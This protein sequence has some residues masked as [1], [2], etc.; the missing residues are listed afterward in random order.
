M[1]PSLRG[2]GGPVAEEESPKSNRPIRVL[3]VDDHALFRRGL[4]ALLSSH[5]GLEIVGER[6]NDEEALIQAQHLRPDVVIMQVQMPFE[7]AQ[8]SLLK[9]GEG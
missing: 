3:L 4:A 2:K 6:P 1:W 5:G 9:D 7:R 8:E